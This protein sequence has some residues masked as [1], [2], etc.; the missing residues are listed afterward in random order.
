[1][2]RDPD[3]LF[4]T[5]L[6]VLAILGLMGLLAMVFHKAFTDLALLWQ[7]HSGTDFWPAVVR[8]VFKNLAG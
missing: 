5:V 4:K 1:M 8:Y 3:A 7:Q 2:P 6:Q